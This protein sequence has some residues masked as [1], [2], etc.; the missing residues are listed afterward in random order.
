MFKYFT[1]KKLLYYIQY[2][3]YNM[4]QYKIMHETAIDK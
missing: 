3:N 4:Q 1:F 2:I